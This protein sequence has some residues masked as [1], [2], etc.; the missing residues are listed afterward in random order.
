MD[1][2]I[3]AIRAATVTGASDEIRSAGAQACRTILTALEAKPGQPLAVPGAADLAALVA[4]VRSV[5]VDQLLDL[6]IAKLRTMVP[7]DST[8][9]VA[10]LNIP[11]APIPRSS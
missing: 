4:G 5:P 1:A 9:P 3:E 7:A 10:R 6:A 11:L 2:L 8:Q